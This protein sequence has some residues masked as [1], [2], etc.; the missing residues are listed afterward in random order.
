MSPKLSEARI[1]YAGYS[2]DFSH[3]GDR[4]RF[5]A[6]AAQKGLAYER[7]ALGSPYDLVLVTHNGDIAG[8][9]ARKRREG[10]RLKFVFEL[11]DSYFVQ[12]APARRFIKGS[13]RFLLGTES[14]LS[15]DFYRTLV[16]ACEAADAVICSTLEQREQIL[17]YNPNV[18]MSFDWFGGDL[19]APK[20][21]YRRGD[22]LRLVWE[23]QSTTVPNLQVLREPL[24][25]L[26]DKIEL[27]VVTDP[28]IYRYF[29]RY[30]A[31]P[32]AKALL[33]I[34]CPIV[35]HEWQRGSFDRHITASDLAVIP[36]E[37]HNALW[38]GKPE[39]KLVLLWK[40]GM[41]VLTTST[42]VYERTMAAAGLD[43]VCENVADWG[44]KLQR[45]IDAPAPELE[46][47]GLHGREHAGRAYSDAA[48]R[49]AFDTAFASVGFDPS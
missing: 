47:I 24:N 8:W 46:R 45:M 17:R 41:P 25:D 5:S 31:Y 19:G 35:M 48:F 33:G 7:A 20:A 14:R 13:A 28:V 42:P 1:G 29:G 3:P 30:A 23:G 2:A 11:A 40:L 37:T 16:H 36:I 43:M 49:N 10:N 26:R 12:T 18:V 38:R 32:T 44:E 6:Y 27:H 22:R 9:T 21:D 34:E 15:P 4:R 39:N